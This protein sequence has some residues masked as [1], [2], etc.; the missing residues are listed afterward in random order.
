VKLDLSQYKNVGA[1]MER[2]K[3]RPKVQEAL[4]DEGLSH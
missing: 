1:F 3:K 4:K 2:M